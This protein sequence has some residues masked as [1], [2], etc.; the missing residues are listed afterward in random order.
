MSMGK[1]I[2]KM[3]PLCIIGVDL[4]LLVESFLLLPSLRIQ[5]H[6]VWGET[7]DGGLWCLEGFDVEVNAKTPV[8]V[9]TWEKKE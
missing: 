9:E 6:P 1:V 8:A 3:K 4:N 2:L 7:A 5:T